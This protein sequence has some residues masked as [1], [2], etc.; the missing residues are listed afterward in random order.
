VVGSVEDVLGALDRLS[1]D[2]AREDAPPIGELMAAVARRQALIERLAAFQP[3]DPAIAERLAHIAK[4]GDTAAIRLDA[5]R[6][7][8][9]REIEEMDRMRRFAEGLGHTVPDRAPR[10]NARG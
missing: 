6:E 1:A 2:M 4:L 5:A 8:L 7:A 10:L 9:R 3:L